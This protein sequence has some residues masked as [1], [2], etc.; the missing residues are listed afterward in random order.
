MKLATLND[1]SRDGRLVVVSRDL[2]HAVD[3]ASVAAT[4]HFAMDHWDWVE[5]GLRSLSVALN[6]GIP[7]GRFP[8]VAEQAMA[9]LPR[10]NQFV[11]ASAFLNHGNIMERAFNIHVKRPDGVPILVQ[12][13]SDDFCGARDDYPL[14]GEAENGDFEGEFA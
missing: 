12:R 13:Q 8:F 11:D 4:M 7:A 1:G 10:T 9:P 6:G 2:A 5:P 3:A 14:L